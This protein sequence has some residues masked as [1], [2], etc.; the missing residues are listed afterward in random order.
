M[1]GL[2]FSGER[3]IP[4]S[5]GFKKGYHIIFKLSG[6]FLIVEYSWQKFKGKDRVLFICVSPVPS[7]IPHIEQLMDEEDRIHYREPKESRERNEAGK[8]GSVGGR[9]CGVCLYS[10]TRW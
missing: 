8:T 6:Y 5:L 4:S 7:A 10:V 3:W 1:H 2:G 9:C